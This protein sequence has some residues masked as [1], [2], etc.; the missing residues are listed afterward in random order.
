MTMPATRR[1]PEWIESSVPHQ[2]REPHHRLHHQEDGD[3]EREHA[4]Q[5]DQAHGHEH[6]HAHAQVLLERCFELLWTCTG[7][8]SLEDLH[9][10]YVWK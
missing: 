9:K 1:G 3:D 8:D 5:W 7:S 10:G 2:V 4:D 6:D